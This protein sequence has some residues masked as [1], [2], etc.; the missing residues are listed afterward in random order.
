MAKEGG[1]WNVTPPPPTRKNLNH[2]LLD[3]F[4][5]VDLWAHPSSTRTKLKVVNICEMDGT[6]GIKVLVLCAF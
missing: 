6:V 1:E 3:L 5:I 2:C 4:L